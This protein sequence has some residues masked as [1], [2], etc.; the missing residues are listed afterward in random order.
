M[1]TTK[2][3]KCGTNGQPWP[4]PSSAVT[5][6]A[7]ANVEI[8]IPLRLISEVSSFIEAWVL[9]QRG[10]FNDLTTSALYGLSIMRHPNT[11]CEEGDHAVRRHFFTPWSPELCTWGLGC[12][13][14]GYGCKETATAPICGSDTGGCHASGSHSCAQ[15]RERC[16]LQ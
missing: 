4:E 16:Y 8:F 11:G 1:G 15:Y 6:W 3:P 7:L 12:N 5:P 2:A 14:P 13:T 9:K 10:G